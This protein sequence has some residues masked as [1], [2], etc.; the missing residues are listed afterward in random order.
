MDN[1]P[2][3]M[4]QFSVALGSYSSQQLSAYMQFTEARRS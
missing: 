4:N 2:G 1:V 3:L